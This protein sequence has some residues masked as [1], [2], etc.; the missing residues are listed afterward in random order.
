MKHYI[1]ISRVEGVASRQA[2]C[3]LPAGTYEREMSKEGFFGPAAFF[4]HR[5]PPT[6]WIEFEGPL[7]PARPRPDAAGGIRRRPAPGRRPK[8]SRMRRAVCAS[9]A[10]RTAWTRLARN[11]DGDELL[12]VHAARPRPVL[13]LRPSGLR[14]G[15]YV[16]LPRGTMW[17]LE[18]AAPIDVLLIES[19]NASYRLPDR[20]LV[21][22]H[23]IFDPAMLDTPRIDDA[24]KAQQSSTPGLAGRG[25]APRRDLAH[26][27]SR[28]TRSMRS[29]GTASSRR[30]DSTCATSVR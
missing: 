1:P 18:V 20:G 27:L 26:H 3:D 2:H 23:A 16:M 10:W 7:R 15:D 4:H 21:G 8:C 25:Q 19:T 28:S 9:G 11:A 6:G 17:R 5:H 12:F 29:A 13:R 22:P 14:A 24:F 30:C